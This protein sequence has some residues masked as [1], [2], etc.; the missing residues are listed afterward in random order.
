MIYD[1]IIIGGGPTGLSAAIYGLRANKTV[2]VL[3]K[4]N[5]GGQILKTKSVENYPGFKEIS[6]MELGTSMYEQAKELGMVSC[7]GEV[8]R[9]EKTDALFEVSVSDHVYVGKTVIVATGSTH[10]SLDVK[11]SETYLGKGLSYCATCDG[12]FFRNQVVAVIGGGNTAIADALYL[13]N[14]CKTVYVIHRREEFRAEASK[15]SLLKEKKNVTFLTNQVVT[16]IVGTDEIEA[17]V[18]NDVSTQK[19][20]KILVDGVFV[21]IGQVP[22]TTLL[23]DMV[24]LSKDGSALV[25]MDCKSEVPG[26]FVAGDVRDKKIRQLTTATSDGTVAAMSAIEYLEA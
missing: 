4:E 8:V 25:G 13:A 23:H 9:L 1:M 7:Y 26:L 24:P 5:F 12:A 16:E 19:E 3:E 17:L 11:N 20:K 2:L 14:I 6:G 18:L 15:L 21:A 10:R 22:N